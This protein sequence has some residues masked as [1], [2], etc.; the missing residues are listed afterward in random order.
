VRECPPS[1]QDP[2]MFDHID[3]PVSDLAA[4]VAF[5]SL[6]LTP[7]GYAQTSREPPEFGALSFV[8]RRAPEQLHVAF[9]AES[10]AAVETFHRAGVDAGFESNGAPGPR[11]Y[12]R[13]YYAA[14]L[15]DPDG[16]NVEAVFRSA[17]TRAGWTWLGAGL[18][19]P[20]DE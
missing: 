10:Q 9:I 7:L 4:S 1:G 18:A 13:D 12:A 20:S 11:K 19:R 6:V 14:Y 3:L 16:H 8:H 15:L 2:R 17:E 5:Y